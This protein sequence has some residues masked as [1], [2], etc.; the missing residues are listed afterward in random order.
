M[1]CAD[2][3]TTLWGLWANGE[4]KDP[5][6]VIRMEC[7]SLADG[8]RRISQR[9]R[10]AVEEFQPVLMKAGAVLG[11]RGV[12]LVLSSRTYRDR[13]VSLRTRSDRRGDVFVLGSEAGTEYDCVRRVIRQ[14]LE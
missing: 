1:N 7:L 13:D 8:Q 2:R 12:I 11:H 10:S 14:R 5:L 9:V 3:L 6:V 4:P